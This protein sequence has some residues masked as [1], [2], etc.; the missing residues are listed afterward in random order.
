MW[1]KITSTPSMC[2]AED[3]FS[4]EIVRRRDET[5]N[6]SWWLRC[7]TDGGRKW[8]DV[9]LHVCRA[10]PSAF[11]ACIHNRNH[12]S[13][14]STTSIRSY[15]ELLPTRLDMHR[16]LSERPTVKTFFLIWYHYYKKSPFVWMSLVFCFFL[17]QFVVFS[18]LWCFLQPQ[19]NTHGF[20]GTFKIK[21]SEGWPCISLFVFAALQRQYMFIQ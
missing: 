19:D 3:T 18:R 8:M 12:T 1:E 20:F 7:Q 6:A 14:N 10:W 2:S 5:I 21:G 13:S 9:V 17:V 16:C 11:E 15:I 4:D